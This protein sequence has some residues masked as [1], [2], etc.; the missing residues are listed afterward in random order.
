M[1]IQSSL[2]INFAS[3][4]GL[5]GTGTA[6]I[7]MNSASSSFTSP[8]LQL[9]HSALTTL[10]MSDGSLTASGYILVG[11]GAGGDT[12]ITMSGG[13]AFAEQLYLGYGTAGTIYIL[14]TICRPGNKS[15]RQS[16]SGDYETSCRQIQRS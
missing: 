2:N 5:G 11:T 14:H 15:G 16:F 3:Y 13:T 12:V 10:N 6:D 7:Y 1:D 4:I 9:G 8:Y